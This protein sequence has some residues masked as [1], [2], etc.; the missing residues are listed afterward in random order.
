[1]WRYFWLGSQMKIRNMLL[2]T[3][4]KV[5]IVLKW[6][7]YQLMQWPLVY[8][9]PFIICSMDSE[10]VNSLK[11]VTVLW[12][13]PWCIFLWNSFLILSCSFMSPLMLSW[14]IASFEINSQFL[15][16]FKYS[17]AQEYMML[18]TLIFYCP[19]L[20]LY[21]KSL[22]RESYLNPLD[23]PTLYFDTDAP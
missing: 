18:I 3:G 14:S 19:I 22:S 4:G 13:H 12:L 23:N 10:Y 11:W 7:P 20:W 1:M 2:E 9:L 5:I 17:T 6:Q 8:S 15:V 21:I 16:W